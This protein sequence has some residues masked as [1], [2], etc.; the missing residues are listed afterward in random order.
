MWGE[1]RVIP[2][3]R[4]NFYK[5]LIKPLDA[6][7]FIVF[8]KGYKEEDID[9]LNENV[10]SKKLYDKPNKDIYVNYDK[11]TK[12][13]NYLIDS[14]LQV[15][16][17]F[18]FIYQNYGDVFEQ[19]YEYIIMT[20]SDFMHVFE[21]PDILDVINTNKRNEVELSNNKNIFWLYDGMEY[22]GISLNFMCVPSAYIKEYL[23]VSYEFLQDKN[24]INELNSL[25]LNNEKYFKLI[26]DKKKWEIG[27]IQNNAFISCD[28]ENEKSTWGTI[29]YSE[30]HN[31]CYK[32]DEQLNNTYTALEQYTNNQ[33]WIYNDEKKY[34]G[35]SQ[36]ENFTPVGV[37]NYY[38]TSYGG[39]P[40][41][42]CD[43]YN[44]FIIFLLVVFVIIIIYNIIVGN[45][46]R[47][48]F[49][50]RVEKGRERRFPTIYK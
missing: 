25:V 23:K 3:I 29:K 7:L 9:L 17:N 26:F 22:G 27:K 12:N 16:Y 20:R 49:V 47:L 43:L 15:Y 4:D 41:N 39:F 11:L 14:I 50:K 46:R 2:I 36:V 48:P 1:P 21:F 19:N 28:K 44:L 38:T 30:K 18:Y 24:N 37:F 31:V 6:D 13:D 8:Q 45:L 10:V 32:Y 5:N 33:R 34:I 40:E 42:T 35:L